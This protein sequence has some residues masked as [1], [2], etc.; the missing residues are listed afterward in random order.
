MSVNAASATSLKR[1]RAFSLLELLVVMM[2]VVM[3][4]TMV[5]LAVSS[6]SQDIRLQSFVYNLADVSS[7]ALD[8]AQMTGQD[9]GL[10]L[11]EEYEDG[12]KF[13]SYNW[14]ERR[15]EGWEEVDA[16]QEVFASQ[17]MPE[18]IELELELEDGPFSEREIELNEDG[19]ELIAPQ[20]VFYSSGETTVGAINV[21]DTA[22]GDLMWR[23]EWDLLGRFDVL[24]RG[25]PEEG[26]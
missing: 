11:R 12:A 1:Q 23:I 17:D 16:R 15:L 10:L 24:L 5:S 21:R 9:Y 6:G 13:Y 18:G 25:E 19:E 20:V 3:I 7:Y 14:F 2:V 26:E 8:E 4:T 22:T